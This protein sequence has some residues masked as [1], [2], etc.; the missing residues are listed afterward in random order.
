[1]ETLYVVFFILLLA[2]RKKEATADPYITCLVVQPSEKVV[3]IF[4]VSTAVVTTKPFSP[5]RA[6]VGSTILGTPLKSR[7]NTVPAYDPSFMTVCSLQ[8][9]F[10]L[11]YIRNWWIYSR[12]MHEMQEYYCSIPRT[13]RLEIGRNR[14]ACVTL[15]C[16]LLCVWSETVDKPMWFIL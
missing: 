13:W 4:V 16:Y 1:M 3:Q 10:L 7:Q 15:I 6:T 8:S 2:P 12:F 11:L 9:D 5:L 14:V